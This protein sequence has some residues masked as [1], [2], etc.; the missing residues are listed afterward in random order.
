MVFIKMLNLDLVG[1]SS[2][3][4]MLGIG[5]ESRGK[6]FMNIILEIKCVRQLDIKII[7]PKLMHIVIIERKP[8]QSPGSSEPD[9]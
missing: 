2:K 4:W 5:V 7:P 6:G 9:V 8:R 1:F 3:K